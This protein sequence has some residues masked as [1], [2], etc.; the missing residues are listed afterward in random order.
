MK[1]NNIMLDLETMSLSPYAAIIAIGAVRFDDEKILDKFYMTIDLSSSVEAGMHMSA[2]TVLWW[3]KQ[4]DEARKQFLNDNTDIVTALIAFSDWVG[5]NAVVW[6]NGSAFDNVILS[7]AYE[8]LAIQQPWP[9]TNDRCY[10]TVKN[11]YPN[12]L[13]DRIGTHHNAI[14][15]AE[16]QALHLIKILQ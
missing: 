4:K 1:S 6:G 12:I 8:L 5:D 16:S 10:R 15:D 2:N 11:L 13:L 7:N 9:Y 3:M 14:N